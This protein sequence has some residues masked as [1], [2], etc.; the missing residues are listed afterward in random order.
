MEPPKPEDEG[1]G[2]VNSS[3]FVCFESTGGPPQSLGVHDRGLFDDNASL[4]SVE[5]DLGSEACWARAC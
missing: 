1:E 2:V 5:H 3:E 4:A